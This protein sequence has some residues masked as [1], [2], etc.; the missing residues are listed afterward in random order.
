MGIPTSDLNDFTVCDM[1][2]LCAPVLTNLDY[3]KQLTNVVLKKDCILTDVESW[4]NGRSSSQ[5]WSNWEKVKDCGPSERAVAG[6]GWVSIISPSFKINER[7]KRGYWTFYC[8]WSYQ[9]CCDWSS[10]QKSPCQFLQNL[11]VQ[12]NLQDETSDWQV[13]NFLLQERFYE[14]AHISQERLL[15]LFRV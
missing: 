14:V 15:T 3:L 7:G 5:R 10:K 9:S 8:M 1:I 13:Y 11:P 6:F 4:I 12:Q 2:L